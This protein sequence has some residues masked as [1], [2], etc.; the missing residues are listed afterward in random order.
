MRVVM[1]QNIDKVVVLKSDLQNAVWCI[2]IVGNKLHEDIFKFDDVYAEYNH[3]KDNVYKGL[4]PTDVSEDAEELRGLI[5]AAKPSDTLL[6]ITKN[7]DGKRRMIFILWLHKMSSCFK[8]GEVIF[9]T[10]R[11]NKHYI[12]NLKLPDEVLLSLEI[13]LNGMDEQDLVVL[14]NTIQNLGRPL[15]NI[16]LQ[17]VKCLKNPD[18]FI[19]GLYNVELVNIADDN[20]KLAELANQITHRNHFIWQSNIEV[21]LSLD[22]WQKII[23][24]WHSILP[25]RLDLRSNKLPYLK[26][27]DEA[28]TRGVYREV[29]KKAFGMHAQSVSNSI[30]WSVAYEFYSV[31][32]SCIAGMGN[33]FFEKMLA[34]IEDNLDGNNL[35]ELELNN[36]LSQKNI[37]A[38]IAWVKDKSPNLP[39]ATLAIGMSKDTNIQGLLEALKGTSIKVVELIF[40]YQYQSEL[41]D[42]I[43][44]E[45]IAKHADYPVGIKIRNSCNM[46]VSESYAIFPKFYDKMVENIRKTNPAQ[47]IAYRETKEELDATSL[48][49]EEINTDAPITLEFVVAEVVEQRLEVAEVENLN[50]DLDNQQQEYALFDG[51]LVDH[52]QYGSQPYYNMRLNHYFYSLQHKRSHEYSLVFNELFGNLPNAIKFFSLDAAAYLARNECAFSTLNITNLD[53]GF[54]IKKTAKGELVLDYDQYSLECTSNVFTPKA[55]KTFQY[56]EALYNIQLSEAAVRACVNNDKQFESLFFKKSR[57]QYDWDATRQYSP[58]KELVNLWIRFGEKGVSEFFGKINEVDKVHNGFAEFLFANY[59]AYFSQWDHFYNPEFAH[60]LDRIKGYDTAQLSCLK[61][62]LESTGISRTDLKDALDAFDEFWR[63]YSV[64]YSGDLSIISIKS[65][66]TPYGGNPVVY[67]E[68]LLTILENA[69]NIEEQLEYLDGIVLSSYGAYYASKFEGFKLVSKEMALTYCK[70]EQNKLLFNPNKKVYRVELDELHNIQEHLDPQSVHQ[71]FLAKAYRFIGQQSHGIRMQD[72]AQGLD[73]YSITYGQECNPQVLV[74]SLFF[75]SHERSQ[76]EYSFY[77]ELLSCIEKQN[78]HKLIF[79]INTALLYLYKRDIKLNEREGVVISQRVALMNSAE[80]EELGLNKSDS[81]FKLFRHLSEN[82]YGTLKLLSMFL[83]EENFNDKWPYIFAID[84]ADYLV[85]KSS[86]INLVYKDQL[87]LFCFLLNSN[88]DECYYEGRIKGDVVGIK[89]KLDD[90]GKWLSKAADSKKPNNLDT[91]F[92]IICDSRK[93]F[94]YKMFLEAFAEIDQMEVVDYQKVYE[95]LQKH[96]FV[97]KAEM[98]DIFKRDNTDVKRCLVEFIYVLEEVAK[99]GIDGDDPFSKLEEGKAKCSA[100]FKESINVLQSRLNELWKT[101]GYLLNAIGKVGMIAKLGQLKNCLIADAIST[102]SDPSM[103]DVLSRNLGKLNNFNASTFDGVNHLYNECINIVILFSKL[104]QGEVSKSQEFRKLFENVEF[105]RLSY[106]ALFSILTLITQMPQRNYCGILSRLITN[107]DIIKNQDALQLLIQDTERLNNANFPDNY[108]EN[109]IDLYPKDKT[110]QQCFTGFIKNII[111]IFEKDNDDALLVFINKNPRAISFKSIIKLIELAQKI[112]GC[113]AHIAKLCRAL[114]TLQPPQLET[115]L[116]EAISAEALEIMARCNAVTSDKT[117]EQTINYPELANYITNLSSGNTAKLLKACM[118][119]TPNI[120]CLY[121]ALKTRNKEQPFDDFLSSFEKEPFGKRDFAKQFDVSQVERIVNRSMDLGNKKTYTYQYRK[122]WMEAFLFVN[123]AGEELMIYKGKAAK[124]LSNLEIRELFQ[125]IKSSKNKANLNPLKRRL[126]LLA[127]MREAMYRSTNEH[128]NS[129]QMLEIINC[130]MQNN[131]KVIDEIDTGQGK[132]LI[133][134]MKASLLWLD[135]GVDMT[136]FSIEDAKR[137]IEHYFPYLDLL[138][139]PNSKAPITSNSKFED[140]KPDDVIISTVPQLS[141]AKAKAIHEGKHI[142]K[143][144]AL[145]LGEYDNAALDDQ[146][147]YRYATTANAPVKCGNEWVYH[148]INSYVDSGYTG[149]KGLRRHL[150]SVASRNKK[151]PKMIKGFDDEQLLIWLQSARSVKEKLREDYEYFIPKNKEFKMINGVLQRTRVARVINKIDAQISRDVQLANGAQQLLY[152]R[153]GSDFIIQPESR[154][155]WSSNN[156]NFIDSYDHIWGSSGTVGSSLEMVEQSISYGFA[157]ARIEPYHE[158]IVKSHQIISA[159]GK[160][161]HFAKI[162]EHLINKRLKNGVPYVVFVKDIKTA[163]ELYKE[164]SEEFKNNIQLFTGGE[165]QEEIIASASTKGMITVTTKALGRNT[166]FGNIDVLQT[167][168]DSWRRTKQ[169]KGRTGRQGKP[170]NDYHIYNSEDLDGKTIEEFQEEQDKSAAKDRSYNER[171]YNILGYFANIIKEIKP[172]GEAT[173]KSLL[174][175]WGRC[176]DSIEKKY[177]RLAAIEEF[178]KIALGIFKHDFV[179][180]DDIQQI[181]EERLAE[182]IYKKHEA[183]K[184]YA[185]YNREVKLEDCAP[186]AAIAYE[187]I[188]SE[189]VHKSLVPAEAEEFSSKIKSLL[190]SVAK[191]DLG[192]AT[193]NYF[194]HLYKANTSLQTIKP[195]HAQELSTFLR[196]HIK[197]SENMGL[198]KRWLG[199][200]SDLSKIAGDKNH[201]IMFKALAGAGGSHECDMTDVI[202]ESAIRLLDDYLATSY[203]VSRTKVTTELKESI[204]RADTAKKIV[205]LLASAKV[206]V[207]TED[208]ESDKTCWFKKINY[209]GNSRFQNTLDSSLGLAYALSGEASDSLIP[210]LLGVV[211][212][213]KPASM[214]FDALKISIA[215]IVDKCSTA[216]VVMKGLNIAI[217]RL[218]SSSPASASLRG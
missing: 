11:I 204:A 44:I 8:E 76:R 216:K 148:A 95:I 182:H 106:E 58:P 93:L 122:Q 105:S 137:D 110:E 39:I 90:V 190:N 111:S 202:K 40:D 35:T 131:S 7:F 126:Y 34:H 140:V 25:Y 68:R 74:S 53:V 117:R 85:E 195:L 157:F 41:S 87:L 151:S 97:I 120:P 158:D 141:L 196:N 55:V 199:Y 153:L 86:N 113:N 217:N 134:T 179:D 178:H 48:D 18:Q 54:S 28:L 165:D 59:L 130:M 128:P 215:D 61:K 67:M 123:A 22:P 210:D 146:V 1:Q 100:L 10:L 143:G 135:R 63:R 6:K 46:S 72:F 96:G 47:L 172:S 56:N 177:R 205:E 116:S 114:Q 78:N 102:I 50:Q 213:H 36:E 129:M 193:N 191:G 155:V 3:L 207:L 112:T 66:S 21:T 145:V 82:K 69:R 109:L 160:D 162:K 212:I 214:T 108:I 80:F 45:K 150:M 99:N 89:C 2:D 161:Q 5:A 75:I 174:D 15:H 156:K 32:N 43:L 170:G 187:V 192:T 33:L 77:H 138:G 70:D 147:I 139:I 185:V 91:A 81:V 171:L 14:R 13:D 24:K 42:E 181:S 12:A 37:D 9:T 168:P 107:Y 132:S 194:Q 16:T 79:D 211:N 57:G 118:V 20:P 167:S 23:E 176:R 203:F 125:E 29:F 175:K 98:P 206:K 62:F 209:F 198:L 152:A 124:D 94:E 101:H 19:E 4:K 144:R 127:L 88:A 197:A 173:K 71:A 115:F 119:G 26:F 73:K 186:P 164:L 136:T 142:E 159:E 92:H 49:E 166:D 104:E 180:E 84:S 52:S 154:T 200:E 83:S 133:D 51:E 218:L 65:W 149:I 64:L 169:K 27:F 30:H 38:L 184:E 201:L 31:I 188:N 208:L 60:S 121:H 183:A 189:D 17:N 163:K 103:L